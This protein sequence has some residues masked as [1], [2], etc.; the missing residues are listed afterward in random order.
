LPGEEP[1]PISEEGQDRDVLARVWRLEETVRK[2]LA[3]VQRLEEQR[4]RP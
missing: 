3:R 4:R 2:L 1:L